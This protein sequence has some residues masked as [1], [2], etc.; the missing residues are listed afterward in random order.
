MY[1]KFFE[2]EKVYEKYF[3]EFVVG[4][5]SKLKNYL[6][7]SDVEKGKELIDKF[8]EIQNSF[9]IDN[10]NLYSF[11]GKLFSGKRMPSGEYEKVFDDISGEMLPSWVYLRDP[12][13][14]KNQ[15]LIHFTKHP[16]KIADNGFKHL[17]DDITL[18]GVTNSVD[19]RNSM[20]SKSGFGF[21][22]AL[23]D[24]DKYGKDSYKGEEFWK[25]GDH[26]VLFRSSGIRCW[27]TTDKEYQIIF[28][29]D[30]VNLRDIVPITKSGKKDFSITRFDNNKIIFETDDLNKMVNWIQ[31]NYGQ[32]Y[33]VIVGR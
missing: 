14:I 1:K 20:R 13:L 3:K 32:Y 7:K 31:N 25:Y 33:K 6:T 8:P 26:A 16:I 21:A 30:T 27:H 5:I 18:L 28:K 23:S 19:M 22:F 4:D 11:V 29:G 17:I 9:G 24:Y 2:D 12:I 10:N 15:W